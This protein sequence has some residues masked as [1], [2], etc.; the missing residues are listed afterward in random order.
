MG[1]GREKDAGVCAVIARKRKSSAGITLVL[2]GTASLSAC[3]GDGP[4][5]S[6]DVYSTRADCVQDWGEETKCA[7]AASHLGSGY[8][9][10]PGYL[11]SGSP[12]EAARR[13][14]AIGRARTDSHAIATSHVSRGGFGSS[15][16]LHASTGS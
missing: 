11:Y 15:S 1:Q 10:G 13:G 3:D 5:F 16:S 2:I 9:Y 4:T 7:P 14:E 8:Y 6:R 12:Q